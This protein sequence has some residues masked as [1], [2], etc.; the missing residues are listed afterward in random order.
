MLTRSTSS[1]LTT[2]PRNQVIQEPAR[3]IIISP[4]NV[5]PNKISITVGKPQF[6]PSNP[7][8]P[9][10]NITHQTYLQKNPNQ[11]HFHPPN[12]REIILNR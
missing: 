11:I 6:L 10:L 4:R 3:R 8:T 9:K 1:I 2:Q 5:S 7:Q 12:R